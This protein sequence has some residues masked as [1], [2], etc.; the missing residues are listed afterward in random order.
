MQVARPTK[1]KNDD[2]IVKSGAPVSAKTITAT[3]DKI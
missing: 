1:V 3:I 2:A